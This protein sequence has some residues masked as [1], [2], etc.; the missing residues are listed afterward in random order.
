MAEKK[1]SKQTKK[2]TI[3]DG[4]FNLVG[5]GFGS[6]KGLLRPQ[7][8]LTVV[9]WADTYRMLPLSAAEPG[10]WRTERVEAARG[11]M[12]A[13][14]DPEVHTI[15]VMSCTQLMKTEL[16]NN[17][18]GYFIDN[19]PSAIIVMQPTAKLGEAWSKDRLEKMINDTPSIKKVFSRKSRDASDTIM[20]KE[21]P[22]GH[23]TV[24]GANA[25]SDLAMRPVRIVLCD[26]TD[27]YPPSAGVE[28]DPIDLVT[29]RSDTFWN[30]L[31]VHVC[32]PTIEGRSTIEKKYKEGDQRVFEVPCPHCGHAEEMK[33][34]NVIWPEGEPDKALYH[35][36]ECEK[37]WTETQRIKAISRGKYVATKP[38]KG[39]ASFRANK[40]VSPWKTMGDLAKKFEAA[41]GSAQKLKVFINT[42]LAETWKEKGE[43][44]EWQNLYRRR[45][46]YKI[47][48]VPKGVLFLT[49]GV[50]IQADRIEIEVWGWGRDKQSWSV[51][52]KIF[53]GETSDSDSEPWKELEKYFNK[54]FEDESGRSF[55]IKSAA[56]DSGYNTQTVYNFCRG[57]HSSRR[58]IPVKGR[59]TQELIINQGTIVDLNYRGKRVSR[60]VRV[61]S[62]G[63]SLLKSDFYNLLKLPVPL[64]ET[65]TF[66]AGYVHFPQYDEEYFKQITAEQLYTKKVRGY[67]RQY[68]E[69]IYQRNE[70]LDRRVYARAAAS[71]CGLDRMRDDEWNALEKQVANDAAR[72][73]VIDPKPQKVVRRPSS[74]L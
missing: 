68:W 41:K 43:A 74:W 71:F 72:P 59:D 38:F 2:T 10:R 34:R 47:G 52:Y 25:P 40:L 8:R 60:G 9:E 30:A 55:F 66:P 5:E 11:P 67:D 37:P 51:E 13:V 19:D 12:L 32:S 36:G 27:K 50:D 54:T 44:P 15:T 39:H 48:Q 73:L 33:W 6:I 64:D 63:S 16:I 56:V 69:K 29:E 46:P 45:E 24:V 22:G 42:Q 23:V 65:Q 70:A 14:T 58:I 7:P 31:K 17:I 49:A 28:G 26:E 3:S 21:F 1:K 18:V 20:H 53:E 35:C 62:V 4:H 61:F 57:F